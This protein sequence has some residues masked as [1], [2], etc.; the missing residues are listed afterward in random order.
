[1]DRR[2]S[3]LPPG[4][5]L[6][7]PTTVR[8]PAPTPNVSS[9]LSLS[10][11]ALRA[12][13]PIPPSTGPRQSMFRSQN[14][15]P[16]LQSA[17]KPNF[18][19]TP[20]PSSARRGSIWAGAP[21]SQP[22]SQSM[23]KDPRPLRDRNFQ[24]KERQDILSFLQGAGL[25]ITMPRLSNIQGKDYRAIFEYLVQCLDSS[26]PIDAP[27]KFED[28]FIPALKALR[29]PYVNQLDNKW[30]AAP[31]SMHSWPSLL[32]VLHWLVELC[33]M[34]ENYLSSGHPTLQNTASIPEEFD[35]PMDHRA[36]AFEYYEQAYTIWLDHIDDFVEPNQQLEDRY[37][38]KNERAQQDLDDLTTQLHEAMTE[39]KKLNQSP[40][41]I[42]KVL[43]EN[44]LLLGDSEKFRKILQQY[45][46]RKAKL[47]DA[48]NAEK[49]ELVRH[50]EELSRLKNE[51]ERLQNIVR[52]QN[53]SQEEASRM[54][55]DH[56]SLSRNLEDLR[57][58]IAETHRTVMTLEVHVTNRTASAEEAIDVYTNLLSTLGL[59]PP[60]PPPH[61]N[62]DLTME[63]NSAAS[64]PRQLLI[65]A[66]IRKVVKPT[67]N[68]VA[69]S[70]RTERAQVESERIKVDNELDKMILEC[71]NLDDE[72]TQEER[73]MLTVNE[74]AED[75]HNAAQQEAQVASQEIAR[76]DKEL[77]H[78]RT[79]ALASGM[80]VK[81][82]LESLRF[83]YREQVA[84]VARLKDET[85]RAIIKNSHEIAMFKAEVSKHLQ[86]LR[87]FAEADT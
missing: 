60:L 70:K 3:V 78:A 12:P 30:L 48:I 8:K 9:R 71:E 49:A 67:L 87:E 73:K 36:L 43:D 74:Q 41:P 7:V 82:R 27:G 44:R 76:L 69:E 2:K 84:K 72:I 23:I 18:G 39:L 42:A 26:Y 52:E 32:G 19:R 63:L 14:V 62:V 46:A 38:R 64:D 16:L 68:H 59:F 20:G 79:T 75:L 13:Y 37:A 77:N 65:G 47:A 66:D 24:A 54:T 85:I 55:S 57:Q 1:M 33:K 11:P 53:L 4:S 51:L 45:D 25:D 22:S 5:S 80:G 28:L 58:K 56:E 81:S 29:Y 17:S 6:P 86:D 15:N 31:A 50:D 35:D 61:E 10:G 21:S 34:R 40:A 83:D